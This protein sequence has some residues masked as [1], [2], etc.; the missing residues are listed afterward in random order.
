[1]NEHALT[2]SI[3]ADWEEIP[4]VRRLTAAFLER[5]TLSSEVVDAAAMVVCELTENATKYGVRDG[6]ERP[7][8]DVKVVVGPRDVTIEVSNRVG[9]K[10]DEHLLRLDRTVQWIRGFQDPFE[11][12]LQRLKELTQESIESPESRLG[13][14]RVAYEGQ[15]V[16]DFHVNEQ[17]LLLVSAMRRLETSRSAP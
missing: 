12:Y 2:L 11:A 10:D 9:E 1:M 5:H 17:N 16:L 15:S 8:V 3:A 14:V 6:E 7:V 4:R 13:L